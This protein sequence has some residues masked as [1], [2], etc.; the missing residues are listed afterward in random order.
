VIKEKPREVSFIGNYGLAWK[1]VFDRYSL[2]CYEVESLK[3]ANEVMSATSLLREKGIAVP[4]IVA[5]NDRLIFCEWIDG[6]PLSGQIK[7]MP[8]SVKSMAEYQG[9]IHQTLDQS[10]APIFHQWEWIRGR[11]LKFSRRRLDR[12]SYSAAGDL[13]SKLDG[14]LSNITAKLS[15]TV[16]NPG[17]TPDNLIK[18]ASGK[19]ILVDNESLSTGIG[20]EFDLLYTLKYISNKY[21]ISERSYLDHYSKVCDTA[22]FYRYYSLWEAC[23]AVRIIGKQLTFYRSDSRD[24]YRRLMSLRGKIDG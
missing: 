24:C 10:A 12:N 2:K 11:V 21:E 17:F 22:E 18:S 4:D 15:P 3:K 7:G 13:I 20:K 9:Q 8:E 5:R 23:E 1:V 19:L 14:Q 16:T 6:S